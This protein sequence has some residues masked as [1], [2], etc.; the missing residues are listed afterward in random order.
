[1]TRISILPPDRVSLETNGYYQMSAATWGIVSNLIMIM[2]HCP[3]VTKTLV[4]FAN[5]FIFF[6]IRGSRLDR[7]LRELII[8]KVSLYN[9]SHYSITHHT[10]IALNS[11]VDPQKLLHIRDRQNSIFSERER[12]ALHYAE[13]AST[14]SNAVEDTFF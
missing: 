12:L 6:P 10:L 11:G 4:P 14:D 3:Q 13:L 8:N 1:M 7:N 2:G 5:S 9:Q